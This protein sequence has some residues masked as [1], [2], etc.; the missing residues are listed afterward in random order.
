MFQENFHDGFKLISSNSG[1]FNILFITVLFVVYSLKDWKKILLLFSAFITGDILNMI[2][3]NFILENYPARFIILIPPIVLMATSLI[4]ITQKNES[5]LRW[6]QLL[7]F[8]GIVVFCLTNSLNQLKQHIPGT[9]TTNLNTDVALT[10]GLECGRLLITAI[11]C[12]IAAMLVKIFNV[13]HREMNLVVS[14]AGLGIAIF[15]MLSLG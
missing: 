11:V 12:L 8:V 5:V 15:L 13:K 6:Q 2:M 14:G 1:Y 7:R 4:N 10:L 3:L 9:V